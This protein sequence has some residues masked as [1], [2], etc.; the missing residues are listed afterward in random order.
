MRDCNKRWTWSHIVTHRRIHRRNETAVIFT[1]AVHWDHQPISAQSCAIVRCQQAWDALWKSCFTG[2]CQ[3]PLQAWHGRTILDCD[4]WTILGVFPTLRNALE[5]STP[6]REIVSSVWFMIIQS[7]WGKMTTAPIPLTIA[8]C[9]VKHGK[10][11]W[12]VKDRLHTYSWTF[13]IVTHRIWA[14]E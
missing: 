11:T 6:Y 2:F 1:I 13:H 5:K 4:F 7:Q 14:T 10:R 12:T 3:E 8:L 9:A